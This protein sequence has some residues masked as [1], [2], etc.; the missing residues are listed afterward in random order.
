MSQFSKLSRS[1]KAAAILVA[2]GKGSAGRLLKFFKQEE[3]RALIEAAR[4]LKTIP[5]GELEKIVAEFESE[6]AEGAGLLDSGDTMSNI[7]SETLSQ[8]E[9]AAIMEGTKA[10]VAAEGPPPIWP[11]LEELAPERLSA[12]IENEHPQ[13]IAMI[14]S[15][16]ERSTAAAAVS[17]LPKQV[18]GETIKRMISLGAVPDK[19]RSLVENQLRTRLEEGTGPKDMSAG[20]NRVASML[21]ELDKSVLDEV[22]E[23]VMEAGAPDIETLRSK[24][25]AFEDIVLLSPKSRTALLD[26]APTE[27]VTTALRGASPALTEAV[28]SAIGARSRRMIESELKDAA[29]SP[30]PDEIQKA[31]RRLASDA[32]RL[33][34]EGA[35]EL[36][37]A[38][39]AA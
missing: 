1:Q 10:E 38:Q 36:P 17:R 31:R 33:A 12:L 22:M 9:I 4:T 16:L 20:Q 29:T 6:F 25:F 5:Q 3:L 19:A 18:R 15:N 37:S 7:L 8:D 14:L 11:R 32:I 28:L 34:Q 27:V 2:M 13:T 30:P 21:N 39:A 35:V 24:L 23:D 26:S